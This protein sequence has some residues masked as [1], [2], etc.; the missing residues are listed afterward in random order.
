ML[1]MSP[2]IELHQ[3]DFGYGGKPVLQGVDLHVR[4]GEMVGVLGSNG[5]GKS[6]LLRGLLGLL[7]PMAGKVERNTHRVGYVPQT[8]V[9]DS[10]Y[11]LNAFEVVC[12]GSFA[13]LSG[14]R[15]VRK[16]DRELALECLQRV[17]AGHLASQPYAK[18]SGGQRQRVL[19]AR[20]LMVPPELLILDEP[21]SGVDAR[22]AGIIMQL[23]Q[24][25]VRDGSLGVVL[26]SHQLDLVEQYCSRLVLIDG[27]TVRPAKANS[28]ASSSTSTSFGGEA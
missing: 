28:S 10:L 8:E 16:Q 11:P 21:T 12:M 3:A 22:A 20:G 23:L 19:L 25:L 7:E 17:E 18:L 2:L 13:R 26:V 15:R 4:S 14:T 1:A 5:S 24:G 9:L 27:G 6:T